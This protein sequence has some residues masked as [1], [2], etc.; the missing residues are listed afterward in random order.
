[1]RYTTHSLY[2]TLDRYRAPFGPSWGQQNH[3]ISFDLGLPECSATSVSN[4]YWDRLRDHLRFLPH[5]ATS[6]ITKVLL[7]G[8]CVTNEKFL[9]VLRDALQEYAS[10]EL[11]TVFPPSIKVVNPTFAAARGVAIYARR[12][13]ETKH[14]CTERKIC[15]NERENQ[16]NKKANSNG[17]ERLK[18]ELR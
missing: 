6:R 13:Q 18:I 4:N 15:E 14:L 11:R 12:R 9:D 7:S 10:L 17:R 2:T 5:N 8:E 3:S 16:R 1:L